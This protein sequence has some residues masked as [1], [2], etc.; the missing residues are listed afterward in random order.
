[1]GDFY[2]LFYIIL[3]QSQ[4]MMVSNPITMEVNRKVCVLGPVIRRENMPP[5]IIVSNTVIFRPQRGY[6]RRSCLAAYVAG[7][8]SCM[9]RAKEDSPPR[10]PKHL[11]LTCV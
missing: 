11:E 9:F 2:A 7:S 6:A 4:P 1:M 3:D 5:A 8:M 10:S